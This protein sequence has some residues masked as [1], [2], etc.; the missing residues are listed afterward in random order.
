MNWRSVAIEACVLLF[1]TRDSGETHMCTQRHIRMV[2]AALPVRV[3]NW[4]QPRC[5]LIGEGISKV[6]KII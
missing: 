3:K 1:Y 4:K 6:G 2:I 5:P